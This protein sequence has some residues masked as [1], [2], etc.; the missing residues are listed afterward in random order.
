MQ[1]RKSLEIRGVDG[2][3]GVSMLQSL[4]TTSPSPQ[5]QTLGPTL[6]RSPTTCVSSVSPVTHGIDTH[7]RW[8]TG[9]QSGG[10]DQAPVRPSE[11]RG[12]RLSSS[13]GRVRV[14]GLGPEC[15]P[16]VLAGLVVKS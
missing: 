5:E 7:G 3:L 11:L 1:A 10:G 14:M 8:P 6:P 4:G 15:G 13:R 16:R 12:G 9:A 2:F